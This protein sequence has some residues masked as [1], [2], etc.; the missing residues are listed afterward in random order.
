MLPKSIFRLRF[1]LPVITVYI[2]ATMKAVGS[3]T[4]RIGGS[5]KQIYQKSSQTYGKEIRTM[6]TDLRRRST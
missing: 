5:Q 2:V 3:Q 1:W 6:H 4:E